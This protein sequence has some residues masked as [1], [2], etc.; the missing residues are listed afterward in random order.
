MRCS[1]ASILAISLRWRSRARSSMARSVSDEARSARSGWL[2]F[3]CCRISRVSRA[4]RRMSFFQVDQLGAEV[5][6]L[7]FVH[8]RLVFRGDVI[9]INEVVHSTHPTNPRFARLY[10]RRSKAAQDPIQTRAHAF[11]SADFSGARACTLRG[12]IWQDRGHPS[13]GPADWPKAGC[14]RRNAP[15]NR[16]RA[17]CFTLP[18][19][20]DFPMSQALSAAGTP[21]PAGPGP[22]CAISTG[23]SSRR[24]RRCRCRW[25]LPMRAARLRPR[26]SCCAPPPGA[27][28]RRSTGPRRH[29]GRRRR[30]IFSDTPLQHR[31][32]RLCR[33]HPRE[34]RRA[35]LAAASIGHNPMMEDLATAS[36]GDGD[37]DAR[38]ALV[39]GF[40]TSGWP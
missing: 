5:G 21:K 7:P 28:A 16:P 24:Q 17:I 39:G 27:P 2:A 40:P 22:A 36:S 31:R 30:V 19:G 35:S 23:R 11:V 26:H 33:L 13:Q 18:V 37:A 6:F 34:R 10:I 4:S 15:A 32:R 8:E 12:R 3:S 9:G 1:A 14:T 29:T 38:A 20:E 25:A